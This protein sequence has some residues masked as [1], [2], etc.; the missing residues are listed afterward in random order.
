MLAHHG[1]VV[2]GKTLEAA[3][4]A[5]EELE[6]T[7]RLALLTRGLA[8]RPLAPD[9]VAEVVRRFDVEWDG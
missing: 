2:A 7:A 9:E 8:P 5:I 1:P 3:S 6:A 4:N